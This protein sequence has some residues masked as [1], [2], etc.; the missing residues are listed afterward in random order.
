[1][2]KSRKIDTRISKKKYKEDREKRIERG[3]PV[4]DDD[5]SS[6]GD[7]EEDDEMNENDEVEEEIVFDGNIEKI[8]V[9]RR[10]RGENMTRNV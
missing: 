6:D 10:K 1:M 8:K 5:S 4:T 2:F 3:E 9:K 7:G